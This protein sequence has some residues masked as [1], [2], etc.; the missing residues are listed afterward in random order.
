MKLDRSRPFGTTYGPDAGTLPY[1]QDGV[2]FNVRGDVVD[3]PY[4][5][6]NHP[7]AFVEA[8]A[9]EEAVDGGDGP[10]EDARAFLEEK[11]EADI[12]SAAVKLRDALDKTDNFDDKFVPDPMDRAANIEFILRHAKQA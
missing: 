11:S 6:D 9:P 8:P 1:L 4:N 10:K 7:E 3:C 12:F 2:Y 5:R